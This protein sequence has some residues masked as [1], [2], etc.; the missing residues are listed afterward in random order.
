M[1][2]AYLTHHKIKSGLR[3]ISTATLGIATVMTP[4]SNDERAVTRVTK[5]ITI[6]VVNLDGSCPS[7]REVPFGD[8]TSNLG[9]AVAS[10]RDTCAS[11]LGRPEAVA[12]DGL[13]T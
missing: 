10:D 9:A 2:S 1:L 5:I 11:L 4:A 6:V 12:R 3:S 7:T 13:D 8:V